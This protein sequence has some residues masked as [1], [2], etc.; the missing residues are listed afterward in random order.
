[1]DKTASDFLLDKLYKAI[2]ITKYNHSKGPINSYSMKNFFEIR[3]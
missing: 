1:M 3:F 2:V